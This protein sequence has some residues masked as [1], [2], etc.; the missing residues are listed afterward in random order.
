MISPGPDL[1]ERGAVLATVKAAARGA[2]R[3]AGRDEKTAP[4][5]ELRNWTRYRIFL[6]NFPDTTPP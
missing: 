1:P 2:T 6:Q 5:V 3:K 4:S